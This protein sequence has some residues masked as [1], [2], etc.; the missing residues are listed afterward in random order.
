MPD[1]RIP[2]REPNQERGDGLERELRELGAR[3]DYPPTP[4]LAG[5]VRR[6]IDGEAPRAAARRSPPVWAI[7]AALLAVFIVVPAISFAVFEPFGGG[8]MSGGEQA[9]GGGGGKVEDAAPQVARDGSMADDTSSSAGSDS[10]A[11]MS[12]ETDADVPSS[13]GDPAPPLGKELGLGE[14]I[15]LETA[16][17]KM[18]SLLLPSGLGRPDETY[19]VEGPTGNGVAFVYAA[20]EDLPPTGD[21]V[22]GLVLT[23][24]PGDV[25]TAFGTGTGTV[26][27]AAEVA[28][29]E[30][31]GIWLSA[32]ESPGAEA[33][34]LTPDLR[35]SALFFTRGGVA[36]RLES[37]LAREEV[38]GLAES[39]Q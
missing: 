18:G 23:E 33:L 11:A 28:V 5:A 25:E 38:I 4:D 27:A 29:G 12:A 26:D 32:P 7:A 1:R 24:L 9:A 21:T 10:D 30:T 36:L 6:L 20:R 8:G 31:R 19:A 16:D 17:V 2:G 34:R 35:G 22:A 13:S 37:S 39:V 15:S 14:R 3:L